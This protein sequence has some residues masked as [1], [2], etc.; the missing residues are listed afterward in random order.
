MASNLL[1]R[2]IRLIGRWGINRVRMLKMPSPDPDQ[3]VVLWLPQIP[4]YLCCQCLDV[5]R[6]SVKGLYCVG[7]LG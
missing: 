2:V 1:M 6:H 5:M 4:S 7:F 3:A